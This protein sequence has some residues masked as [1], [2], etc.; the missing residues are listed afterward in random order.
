MNWYRLLSCKLLTSFSLFLIH[1]L[2]VGL[3]DEQACNVSWQEQC[4]SNEVCVAKAAGG[5]AG[6][7]NCLPNFWRD[8]HQHCQPVPPASY[9]HSGVAYA[10]AVLITLLVIVG[11][12]VTL[13]LLNQRY[14]ILVPF[15]AL[16]PT[17]GALSTLVTSSVSRCSARL[18]SLN[19]FG[20]RSGRSRMMDDLSGPED[21]DSIA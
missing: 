2:A 17:C 12:V 19:L 9:N 7:C 20:V 8:D 11:A 5:D 18:S 16:C 14:N 13:V 15:S 21:D 3:T 1:F 4:G 6:S 10:A